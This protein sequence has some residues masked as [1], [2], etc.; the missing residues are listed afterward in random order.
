[1]SER[2]KSTKPESIQAMFSRVA[3]RYDF[4]NRFL[5][6]GQDTRWRKR[7]VR[8]IPDCNGEPAVLDLCAGTLDFSLETRKQFPDASIHASDFCLDMLKIGKPKLLPQNGTQLSCADALALPYKDASFDAVLCGFGVRN[9]ASLEDGLK[10]IFRVL[11]PGGRAL[12]LEFFRPEKAVE[13]LF[14]ATYGRFVIPALGGLLSGDK[15]AYR[16][17]NRSVSQFC[18]VEE[19]RALLEK[20]G[21]QKTSQ[22]AMSFGVAY[23]TEGEKL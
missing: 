21:F 4:L 15:E 1:M 9:L 8:R 6:G 13:K 10:E 22:R 17:L 5:S 14:Y 12:V 7:A 16:Y 19:Y 11:R 18:S 23:L 3:P 2:P 20:T